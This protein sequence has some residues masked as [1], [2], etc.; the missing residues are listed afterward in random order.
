MRRERPDTPRGGTDRFLVASTLGSGA[1]R[2]VGGRLVK[3]HDDRSEMGDE[4][5]GDWQGNR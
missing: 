3:E 1:N 5:V 2:I 4:S